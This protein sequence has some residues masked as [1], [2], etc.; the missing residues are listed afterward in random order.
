MSNGNANRPYQPPV[1][2][3]NFSSTYLAQTY[4]KTVLNSPETAR[5]RTADFDISQSQSI[6]QTNLAQLESLQRQ[7]QQQ[8]IYNVKYDFDKHLYQSFTL[9]MV[10]LVLLDWFFCFRTNW[11]GSR[12]LRNRNNSN[13]LS[14]K[15][16][17]PL[18]NKLSNRENSVSRKI[19]R[20]SRNQSTVQPE[21]VSI[22]AD[23]NNLYK[24]SSFELVVNNLFASDS[25]T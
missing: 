9:W 25:N 14:N 18:G 11:K 1:W 22:L 24:T 7:Q 19:S 12:S 10:I 16:S 2:A 13:L 8:V 4:S 3:W 5:P 21:V 15:G 6:Q 17:W 20:P 23:L